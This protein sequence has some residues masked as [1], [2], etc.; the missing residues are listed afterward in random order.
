MAT[1][2]Y[3]YIYLLG[4]VWGRYPFTGAPLTP[5]PPLFGGGIGPRD[6][7]QGFPAA[8]PQTAGFKLTP[9][10]GPYVLMHRR[11]RLRPI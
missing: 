4:I 8:L 11:P 3:I 5:S 10:S 7:A 1:D 2:R 6:G 9:N